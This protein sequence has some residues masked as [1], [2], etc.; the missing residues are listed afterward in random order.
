VSVFYIKTDDMFSSRL[1]RCGALRFTQAHQKPQRDPGKHSPSGEN[2][3][4]FFFQKWCILVY[5]IF[6]SNGGPQNVAEPGVTYPPPPPLDG[7]GFTQHYIRN[8]TLT[9]AIFSSIAF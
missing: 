2:F 4:E 7:P 6:L 1:Q 8:E 5:F 9:T 3:F